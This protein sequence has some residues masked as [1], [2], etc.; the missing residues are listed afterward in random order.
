MPIQTP[1][2]FIHSRTIF[3]LNFSINTQIILWWTFL[4]SLE[5][6]KS[7]D[8]DEKDLDYKPYDD[9]DYKPYYDEK[10]ENYE[11]NEDQKNSDF[12]DL[13]CSKC[14]AKFDDLMALA[15]HF[16]KKH[17]RVNNR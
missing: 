6:F 7:E 8:E 4:F 5:N 3:T 15:V 14:D 9:K 16:N 13:K 1:F 11:E 10:Y 2:S 17:E 12:T